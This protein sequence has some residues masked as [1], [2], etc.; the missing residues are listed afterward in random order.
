MEKTNEINE[1]IKELD[2][3][4]KSG[5]IKDA[6]FLVQVIYAELYNIYVSAKV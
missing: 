4:I 2:K 1:H 3:L 6:L 5:N